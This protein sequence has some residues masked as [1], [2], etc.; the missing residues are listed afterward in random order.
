MNSL[1]KFVSQS[2][3]DPIQAMND[4]QDAGIISDNC[5]SA[6]DVSNADCLRAIEFLDPL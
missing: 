6:Q 1:E 3:L 2:E 5:V 4:L